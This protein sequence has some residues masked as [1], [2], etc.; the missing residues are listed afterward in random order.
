MRDRAAENGEE[1]L[2]TSFVPEVG[3]LE[4]LEVWGLGVH[5]Q[6]FI[7]SCGPS[8]RPEVSLI[9]LVRFQLTDGVETG[10]TM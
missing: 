7:S 2:E 5:S 4:G 1:C 10:A 3:S 6:V 8:Q 9:A